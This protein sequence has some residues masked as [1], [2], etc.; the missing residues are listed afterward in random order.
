MYLDQPQKTYKQKQP[1][2]LFYY[3]PVGYPP[4]SYYL[5]VPLLPYLYT[6][7]QPRPNN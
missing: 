2:E 3:L 6:K 4:F 7:A 1:A 5:P